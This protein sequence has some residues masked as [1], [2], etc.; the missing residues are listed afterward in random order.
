MYLYKYKEL[1]EV[2]NII[3]I[4]SIPMMSLIFYT[5][6]KDKSVLSEMIIYILELC[7]YTFLFNNERIS[8]FIFFGVIFLLKLLIIFKI[9][10]N[11]SS[12][13]HKFMIAL[14]LS[15]ILN[16]KLEYNLLINLVFNTLIL[17]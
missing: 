15:Y 2:I 6:S 9:K 12:F 10:N 17:K 14:S 13:T 5:I 7:M 4:F 3:V 1:L 8:N 11:V 16:I